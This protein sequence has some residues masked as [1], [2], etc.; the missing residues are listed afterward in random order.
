VFCFSASIETHTK[1]NELLLRCAVPRMIS[2]M[3]DVKMN[4]KLSYMVLIQRL[5][6]CVLAQLA[7]LCI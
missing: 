2:W 6:V 1:E 5:G 7:K 4:T 3:C